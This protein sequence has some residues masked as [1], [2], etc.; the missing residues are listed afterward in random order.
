MNTPP[1]KR[2]ASQPT[3]VFGD[4]GL[5]EQL[6]QVS[7]LSRSVL[8]ALFG[9]TAL[10]LL[11][12]VVGVSLIAALQREPQ[13]TIVPPTTPALQGGLPSADVQAS[14]T[15]P[16][17]TSMPSASNT[18]SP[19]LTATLPPLIPGSAPQ[20]QI[21]FT[22]QVS[23]RAE[24][25][26][27]CVM[28][29]DGSQYRQLTFNG[30]NIYPSF[31]PDNQSAVFI[32]DATGSEDIFEVNM[33]GNISRIT[34]GDGP[35]SAPHISPDGRLILAARLVN[36]LVNGHWE[37]WTMQRDGSDKR[38][39][40]TSPTGQGAWDP[41]WSP[42]GTKILFA[43]DMNGSAQLFTINA[44]GFELAQVSELE[45]LRGR[46]DWSPDGIYI[47][48]YAGPSWEREI[49]LMSPDGT[50]LRAITYGG[51]NLAPSFSP[52]GQWIVF[53]SYRDNYRKEWGCEIYIMT[54]AG[55]DIRRLTENGYCDWQPR[56]SR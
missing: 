25:N 37:L 36:G 6:T 12:I 21:V 10:G 43:S 46:N 44:G 27:I 42:D 39:I 54:V 5:L 38:Y 50:N 31:A 18:P 28:N 7:G 15:A 14:P 56:W 51:N 9:A 1:V 17:V 24:E 23:G 20:G 8:L 19:T 52:D 2:Q 53:T 11:V 35:W 22:C 48:T 40:Y 41:V 30:D 33:E 13:A 47:A 45:D 26:Q 29:V 49:Y 3:S 16:A 32:S 34:Q 4:G 55:T